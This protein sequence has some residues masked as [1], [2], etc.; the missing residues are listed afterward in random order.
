MKKVVRLATVALAAMMMLSGCGEVNQEDKSIVIGF[1]PNESVPESRGF[2]EG[3]AAEVET[4]TGREVEIRRTDSYEA[5]IDAILAGEID[6][7]IS[8]GNQYITAKDD[9]L[10]G[11]NIEVIST[12]A[13][14]GKLEKAGYMAWVATKNGSDLHKE[15]EAAGIEHDLTP[16]GQP[17]LDRL[18]MLEDK[19]FGF[20]SYSSTSGFVVPRSILYGAFGPEGTSQVDDK[21]DFA[22]PSKIKF[23]DLTVAATGDHQGSANAVYNEV[24]DAGAFCCG[25]YWGEQA[26]DAKGLEDYYILAERIVPNEPLWVN[27]DSMGRDTVE[28]IRDHFNGLT[29]ETA[30]EAGKN[31]FGEETIIGGK[32]NSFLS[33][34]DS[35]YQ[36]I[37]EL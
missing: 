25:N 32:E 6:M 24:V 4:A 9:Q 8:G 15:I 22:D 19:R 13:P 7:T 11:D 30:T 17:E 5:L 35:F 21:D 31:M 23:M 10:G 2:R 1:L 18:A 37:R 20:V 34:D 14:E 16:G 36:I 3:L 26:V 33:V 27:V 28:M 12:H 29:Y